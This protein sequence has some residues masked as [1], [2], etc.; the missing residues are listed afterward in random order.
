MNNDLLSPDKAKL[1]SSWLYD[2]FIYE[3]IIFIILKHF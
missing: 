1:S 2:I 3:N